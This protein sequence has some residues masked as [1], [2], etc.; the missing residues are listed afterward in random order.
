MAREKFERDSWLYGS[1]KERK[2]IEK[3]AKTAGETKKPLEASSDQTFE[4]LNESPRER[5]QKSK[6]V[7]WG[8]TANDRVSVTKSKS[9]KPAGDD[10]ENPN[11]PPPSRQLRDPFTAFYVQGIALEPPLPPE[12][13]L[14]LTEENSLHSACLMAKATDACGRGWSFE[15]KDGG[16]VQKPKPLDPNVPVDPNAQPEIGPDG[17]PVPKPGEPPKPGDQ[18]A[19]GQP[20][21]PDAPPKPGEQPQ[22]APGPA[23]PGEAAVCA[24]RPTRSR[25]VGAVSMALATRWT[26]PPVIPGAAMAGRVESKASAWMALTSRSRR[27]RR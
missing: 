22:P 5:I 15:P 19:P 17:K 24:G 3:A 7:N 20:P 9:R 21:V 10:G 2:A 4:F 11:E 12:R 14:N 8:G 23:K 18:S 13:L 25:M 26:R 16:K 6:I 1:T 27:R